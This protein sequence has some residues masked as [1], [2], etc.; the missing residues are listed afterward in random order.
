[1][2]AINIPTTRDARMGRVLA[3]GEIAKCPTHRHTT[4]CATQRVDADPA[5]VSARGGC[6][7]RGKVVRGHCAIGRIPRERTAACILTP[8][9]PLES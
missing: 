7:P 1:M 4:T 2:E 5:C 9:S 3:A 8:D 6:L